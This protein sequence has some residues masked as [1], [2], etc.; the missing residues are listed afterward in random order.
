MGEAVGGGTWEKLLEV[1]PGD[2]EARRNLVHAYFL[3]GN[4]YAKAEQF[5][6]A[7]EYWN[8][9]WALDSTNVSIAHNLALAYEKQDQLE[10]AA[11]YW[12]A[13]V[14][15]WKRQISSVNSGEK[16]VLQARMHTVHTHLA[17]IALKVDNIGRAIAEYR[18]AL[19]YAPEEVRTIVKLA[20]LYMMEGSA[21]RTIQLL[22]RARR[23][24]PTD[25]DVLQQLSLEYGMRGS[26]DRSL[27]YM[28]E[29]LKL[30][31]GN[32]LYQEMVGQYYLGRAED[33]L[34]MKKYEVALRFL[35]EG[36]EVCPGNIELRAFVGA[37][38][39]DMGDKPKAEAAFRETIDIDS[40]D[41]GEHKVRPYIAVAHHYLDNDMMDDAE[42][43]FAEAIEFDPDNPHVYVDIAG[44]YCRL[45]LCEDARRYFEMAKKAK[46]KDASVLV[47]IVDRLIRRECFEYGLQYAKELMSIAPDDPKSYFFLGLAYHLNDMNDEA[48][49][50]LMK[51]MD[52]ATRTGDDETFD[53]IDHLLNH[54][55][56]ESSFGSRFEDVIDRLIGDFDF[57]EE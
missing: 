53:E 22:S 10:E 7:I 19:R 44:E 55:E 27:E 43:Y 26:F 31:P 24:S 16:E 45:D 35:D 12:K 39:L 13:A 46:P 3:R 54:I 11:K 18:Q 52:M 4:D 42:A 14:S 8:K 36:L 1:E 2:D 32:R 5:A 17:D 9:A 49:N 38:Y 23:L 56:F 20:D 6:D 48:L 34:D 21:D 37:V 47:A 41:M 25:T 51:G 33:A 28:K 15:G 30:D 57:E 50:T 40:T 29:I